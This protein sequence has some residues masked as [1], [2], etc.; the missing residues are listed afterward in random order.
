MAQRF[1]TIPTI[2]PKS[3]CLNYSSFWL[4]LYYYVFEKGSWWKGG[5]G[6]AKKSTFAI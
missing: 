4:Y 5:T 3:E 2:N 6:K 1:K